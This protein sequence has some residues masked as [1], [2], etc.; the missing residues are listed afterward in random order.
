MVSTVFSKIVQTGAPPANVSKHAADAHQ[1]LRNKAMEVRRV[2]TLGLLRKTPANLMNRTFVGQ[3]FLFSYDPKTRDKLPFYDAFP[4]V[5][6]FRRERDG[7]YAL[8]M[9]YLPY[10]LRA[11]LM[12]QL[13]SLIN[14]NS[15]DETTRLRLSYQVLLSSSR[16]RFFKPCVKH[17]LNSHVSSRFLYIPPQEWDTSLFLPTERFIGANKQNVFLDSRR[18]IGV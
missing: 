2:D 1:W 8:N 6:P 17:Y 5:F 3:M 4:L 18:K 14:N 13:Y 12:D 15:N 7:F 10:M 16:Y 9:H 11:M